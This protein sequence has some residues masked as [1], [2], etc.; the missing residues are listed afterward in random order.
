MIIHS[1]NG[2]FPEAP[3]IT[4]DKQK[5][6]YHMRDN[7]NI[8]KIFL[9][10]RYL[11][12]NT[13]EPEKTNRI[14]IYPNPSSHIVNIEVPNH[15]NYELTIYNIFGEK[16]FTAVNLEAIDVSNYSRGIYMLTVKYENKFIT[17]KIIKN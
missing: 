3:T 1:N 15:S 5:L 2:L 17:T 13:E 11:T 8:Y 10:Y 14:I 6:Y 7:T 4:T 12:T 16:I 9:K